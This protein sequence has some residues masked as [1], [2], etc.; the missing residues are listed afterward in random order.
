MPYRSHGQVRYWQDEALAQ[1]GLIHGF[2]TR[3]GGVS[4]PPW[5]S[6]N[7]SVSV[8]DSR[9]R[10]R[11]NLRRAFAALERDPAS[12]YDTWLVHDARVVRAEAP[13]GPRV[14]P[15]VADGMVTSNPRVTLVMRFADCAPLL[16]YDPR[17]RVLALGH[18]GWRGTLAGVAPALVL[19][20]VHAYDSR[21]QD[22]VAV[23]GPS[24]GPEEYE[25]GPDVVHA[26]EQ[27]FGP[28]QAAAFLPQRNGRTHFDLWAANAWLLR[29]AGVGQIRVSGIS[30][31]AA[32]DD[33][34][35]HRAEQGRTGRFVV[36]AALPEP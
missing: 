27:A 34:Y 22:M 29:Q 19:A 35:S 31:A 5:H 7:T 23:I 8:G 17:R 18:A 9:E 36:L 33:W 1:L 3:H 12:R 26:V 13:R 24:I 11:E 20:L 15:L 14:P 16:V 4:P 21:P 2:F 30:T 6:L 28:D 32:T 10:V 25:V